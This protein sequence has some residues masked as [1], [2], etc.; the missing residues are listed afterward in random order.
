MH[1]FS[2]SL[3]D[4]HTENAAGIV[5]DRGEIRAGAPKEIVIVTFND[6]EPD[7]WATGS[8]LFADK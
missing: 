6:V 4:F 5:N 1:T 3:E 8:I 2:A 7:S